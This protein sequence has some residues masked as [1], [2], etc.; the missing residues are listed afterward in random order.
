[1][2]YYNKDI[3]LSPFGRYYMGGN[4]LQV[5]A[6]DGREVIPMRGYTDNSI[7][8][9]GGASIF[10]RFTL[11]IRQPIIESNSSTIWVLGFAEA[12]NAWADI[13]EFNPFHSYNSAGIGV[14]MMVPMLGGLIGLDWGYGFDG[15]GSIGGSQFQFSINQS[16]D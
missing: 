14:R 1:M 16:I 6:Y 2:G 8:P 7:S 4:G 12:G 10:D 3:G 11:E 9:Q 15:K 13:R 5:Y